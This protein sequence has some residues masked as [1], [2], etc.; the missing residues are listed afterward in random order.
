M[1]IHTL[2]AFLIFFFL[3]PCP[4]IN[5]KRKDNE[6]KEEILKVNLLFGQLCYFI[7]WKN[8]RFLCIFIH[9]THLGTQNNRGNHVIFHIEFFPTYNMISVYKSIGQIGH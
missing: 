6:K 7:L 4:I 8:V 5:L 2:P 1:L 9:F 3:D